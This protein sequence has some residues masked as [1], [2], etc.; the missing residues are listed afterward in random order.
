M[1][2]PLQV[3][4]RKCMPPTFYLLNIL[5]LMIICIFVS[6]RYLIGIK[7]THIDLLLAN[8]LLVNLIFTRSN[9]Y[10]MIYS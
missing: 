6:R 7:L 2:C 8:R 10:Q 1:I 4:P 5:Y 9:S 3:T